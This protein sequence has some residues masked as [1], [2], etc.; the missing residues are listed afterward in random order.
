MWIP[1]G[2]KHWH[3]AAATAA[4]TH[5]AISERLHGTGATWMEK[6]SDAQYS[7]LVPSTASAT[8][9]AAYAGWPSAV[10]TVS[11]AREVFQE[12]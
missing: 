5:I 9:S 7:A 4:M 10:T 8:A 11:V 6:V 2:Q 3:G 12:K 1:P